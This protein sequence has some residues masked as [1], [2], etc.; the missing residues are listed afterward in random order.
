MNFKQL[1]NQL[2][3][4]CKKQ[5]TKGFNNSMKS[6]CMLLVLL[7]I[8]LASSAQITVKIKNLTVR[9]SLQRIENVSKYKF[10]YSENLPD[11]D[12]R[13][14]VSMKDVSLD[15]AMAAILAGTNLTYEK[16]LSIQCGFEAKEQNCRRLTNQMYLPT[17]IAIS[18]EVIGKDNR[19]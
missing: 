6:F 10:F 16:H 2:R 7:A 19:C 4:N 13:V 5:M 12:H 18:T 15:Q 17:I 3:R 9:K 14:T 11:L 8:S 1:K